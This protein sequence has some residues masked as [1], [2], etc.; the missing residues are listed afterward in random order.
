ME[1]QRV[2]VL[3]QGHKGKDSGAAAPVSQLQPQ[4]NHVKSNRLLKTEASEHWAP[5]G[6]SAD[7]SCPGSRSTLPVL[8]CLLSR[9]S[10]M[11][12]GTWARLQIPFKASVVQIPQPPP[13]HVEHLNVYIPSLLQNMPCPRCELSLTDYKLFEGRER[14]FSLLSASPASSVVLSRGH[15]QAQFW[16]VGTTRLTPAPLASIS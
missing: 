12:F 6:I 13:L 16:L 8:T 5:Y 7:L 1:I 14:S 9:G 15:R 2:Q 4:D 10:D 3:A 11:R